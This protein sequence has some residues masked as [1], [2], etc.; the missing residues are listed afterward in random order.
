MK[1]QD[2]KKKSAGVLSWDNSYSE[3]SEEFLLT[4]EDEH[5][6]Y[7]FLDNGITNVGVK[8]HI[9]SQ[10]AGEKEEECTIALLYQRFKGDSTSEYFTAHS[11]KGYC[12]DAVVSLGF[13]TCSKTPKEWVNDRVSVLIKSMSAID[14]KVDENRDG[15]LQAVPW[16]L[17]S[18]DQDLLV[19]SLTTSS[20]DKT[21]ALSIKQ[22]C[23]YGKEYHVCFPAVTN[24]G[25]KLI[26]L[27]PNQ[28][29]F[30]PMTQYTRPGNQTPAQ[31]ANVRK[32]LAQQGRLVS[33]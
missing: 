6:A 17:M 30:T 23:D 9:I 25:Q 24:I 5:G 33:L 29:E 32:T 15:W 1:R 22:L 20:I 11:G 2:A 13:P 26:R 18:I 14:K 3:F 8:N 19:N 21:I 27:F 16:V 7:P 31:A 4:T 28:A 12:R 10:L